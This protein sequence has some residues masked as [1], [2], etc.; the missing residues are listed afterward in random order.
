MQRRYLGALH[1]IRD[2]LDDQQLFEE[3]FHAGIYL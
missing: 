1:F 3:A 2:F